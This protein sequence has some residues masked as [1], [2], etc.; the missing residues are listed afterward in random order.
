MALLVME[1]GHR[2]PNSVPRLEDESATREKSALHS[3]GCLQ[4]N[5]S[6]TSRE[7]P[8]RYVWHCIQ[9]AGV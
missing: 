2:A 9:R 5:C 4:R 3:C 7:V 1:T 6:H 8:T